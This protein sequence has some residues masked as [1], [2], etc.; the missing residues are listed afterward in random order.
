LWGDLGRGYVLQF[1][2]QTIAKGSRVIRHDDGRYPLSS[3]Q[4]R[5]DFAAKIINPNTRENN[6]PA[7]RGFFVSSVST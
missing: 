1:L 6:K 2:A 7:E 5:D 3:G 4:F